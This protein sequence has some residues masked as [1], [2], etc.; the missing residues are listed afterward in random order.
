MYFSYQTEKL[1]KLL[2]EY[3][4]VELFWFPFNSIINRMLE[5][6]PDFGDTELILSAESFFCSHPIDSVSQ[7]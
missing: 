7:S 3:W 2:N 5:V 4:S 1:A 6:L